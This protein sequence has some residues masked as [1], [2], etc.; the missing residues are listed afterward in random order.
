VPAAAAAA[1]EDPLL[2]A[3]WKHAGFAAAVLAAAVA[4]RLALDPF[5]GSGVPYITLFIAIILIAWRTSTPV[6]AGS[7]IAG[8]IAVNWLF[9]QPRYDF[10]VGSPSDWAGSV[11]YFVITALTLLLGHRMRHTRIALERSEHQLRLIS[12][13]LPALV[14]YINPEYR[15][16]WCNE[17]Y[18]RWFSLRRDDIVGHPMEEVLGSQAWRTIAPHIDEALA[19]RFVEYEAGCPMPTAAPAGS[20]SPTRRT[21]RRAARSSASSPW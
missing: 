17:E 19:G 13:R 2:R 21:R 11:A 12:A 14:S 8:W 18:L 3:A 15:Y 4:V 7:A 20:T 5:V 9:M 1:L 6:A 10:S 16:V